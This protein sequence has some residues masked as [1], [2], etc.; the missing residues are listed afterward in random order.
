MRRA[1]AATFRAHLTSKK[2]L[3]QVAREGG[4]DESEQIENIVWAEALLSDDLR[5]ETHGERTTRYA[6]DLAKARGPSA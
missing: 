3:K 6:A 5:P 1:S 2:H 4:M